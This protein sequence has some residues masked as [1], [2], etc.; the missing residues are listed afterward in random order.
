MEEIPF[1]QRV[2]ILSGIRTADNRGTNNVGN[3]KIESGARKDCKGGT[4]SGNYRVGT[5]NLKCSPSV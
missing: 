2:R 1:G 5:R 4:K 3:P